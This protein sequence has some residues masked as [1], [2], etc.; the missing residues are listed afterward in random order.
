MKQIKRLTVLLLVGLAITAQ[1]QNPVDSIILYNGALQPNPMRGDVLPK[2]EL[3]PTSQSLAL[4][5]PSEV[6]NDTSRFFPPIFHQV[7]LSCVHAA[8]IGY[9]FTYEMNRL[10]GVEAGVWDNQDPNLFPHL[11]SFNFVNGGY[12]YD[13]G[14]PVY[15]GFE[16]VLSNGCPMY[17]D[18]Y[19]SQGVSS[20]VYWMD[21]YEKYYRGMS[22]RV[23]EVKTITLNNNNASVDKL[24]HWLYDHAEASNIGGLAVVCVYTDG[25]E[26]DGR[27]PQQSSHYN[28]LVIRKLGKILPQHMQ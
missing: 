6:S 11:Y 4:Q 3:I 26:T 25:W 8:E 23:V 9:T 20:D 22:N 28:E 1:S 13:E 18:W 19:N 21:G 14:T 24:K 12:G 17:N 16:T 2:S 7:G 10:R 15:S 27:L 5:L